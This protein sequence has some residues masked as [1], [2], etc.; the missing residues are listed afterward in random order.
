MLGRLQ[1]GT[2]GAWRLQT[3][4]LELAPESK[5]LTEL[6]VSKLGRDELSLS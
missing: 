1:V 6:G 2:E 4:E 5:G 3:A